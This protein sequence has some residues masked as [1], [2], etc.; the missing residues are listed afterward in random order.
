MA[1]GTK[2][3]YFKKNKTRNNKKI[4]KQR[5]MKH[6]NKSRKR[7]QIKKSRK[8]KEAGSITQ[9]EL[10]KEQEELKKEQQKFNDNMTA[11]NEMSQKRMMPRGGV[12]SGATAAFSPGSA[13]AP[14]RLKNPWKAAREALNEEAR[15]KAEAEAAKQSER[16]SNLGD[17]AETATKT[18]ASVSNPRRSFWETWAPTKTERYEGYWDPE[19]SR[20]VGVP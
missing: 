6:S 11:I 17:R 13:A 14:K 8:R 1:R 3:R 5:Q 9:E 4:R 2:K 19:N 16:I 15:K 20:A 7:K 18:S 10:K 12:R